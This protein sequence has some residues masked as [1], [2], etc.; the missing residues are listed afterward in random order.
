MNDLPVRML[1][2]KSVIYVANQRGSY[3]VDRGRTVVQAVRRRLPTT[4]ARVRAHARSCAICCGQSGTEVGF[5]SKY[6][7]FP[8]Q[9]LFHRLLHTHQLS[10]GAGTIGQIVADVPSGLILTTSHENNYLGD[11]ISYSSVNRV[12]EFPAYSVLISDFLRFQLIIVHFR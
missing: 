11:L 7:G 3:L 12:R 5:F 4:A 10:S 8:C 6:F 1:I 9:F 2:N